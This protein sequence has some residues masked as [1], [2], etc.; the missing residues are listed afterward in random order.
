MWCDKNLYVI[1]N[2][3]LQ[4]LSQLDMRKTKL[5]LG[6]EVGASQLVEVD[7]NPKVVASIVTHI[8]LD[9]IK[10]TILILWIVPYDDMIN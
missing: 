4:P 9:I 5:G 3:A 7:A 6:I 2:W 10:F 1:A 8:K